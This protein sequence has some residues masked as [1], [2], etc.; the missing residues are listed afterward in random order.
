MNT[1]TLRSELQDS[2]ICYY[3]GI[4]KMPAAGGRLQPKLIRYSFSCT[5]ARAAAHPPDNTKAPGKHDWNTEK[6]NQ[7]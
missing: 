4:F 5:P 1:A 7:L 3:V 2:R 6:R